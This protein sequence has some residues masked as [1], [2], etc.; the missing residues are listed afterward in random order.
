MTAVTASH[1]PG[2][3]QLIT[4]LIPGQLHRPDPP[5]AP[6]PELLAIG[7]VG[8]GEVLAVARLDPSGRV[9]A[10][11][12]LAALGWKPG[13]RLEI[14]A[15]RTAILITAVETGRHG[16]GGRSEIAL[17]AAAR[18]WC[19]IASGTAVLLAAL[20]VRAVLVIHPASAV[21]RLLRPV[22]TRLF[23][24]HDAR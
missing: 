17:P 6:I 9:P 18:Q 2:R 19:G 20:P 15:C 13:Q 11:G 16:V 21:T 7:S 12:V 22:H 14:T 23:K 24:E 10:A 8:E 3:E 5:T 1:P 4:A